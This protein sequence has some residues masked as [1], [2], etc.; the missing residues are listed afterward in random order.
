MIK[1]NKFNAEISALYKKIK[2]HNTSIYEK[3][4]KIKNEKR[5]FIFK[6]KLYY[7]DLSEFDGKSL[8]HIVALDSDGQE[9]YL[10]T[11]EIVEIENGKLCCSSFNGGIVEWDSEENSYCKSYYGKSKKLDILGFIDIII[12]DD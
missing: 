6:N 5:E 9:I 2:N 7:T 4:S 11:D 12:D 10:P 1:I 3:I 8:S